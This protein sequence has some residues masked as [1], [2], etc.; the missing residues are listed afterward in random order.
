MKQFSLAT[1]EWTRTTIL[2][3]FG[4]IQGEL[5]SLK[6]LSLFSLLKQNITSSIELLVINTLSAEQDDSGMNN[7]V[8][9]KCIK[10]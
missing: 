3:E 5:L 2:R 9:Y 1:S 10:L 6:N 4:H 8:D 7:T